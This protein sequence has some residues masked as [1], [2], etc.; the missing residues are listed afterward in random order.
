[1]VRKNEL[2]IF[3]N[4][5]CAVLALQS[6]AEVI[7]S[8]RASLADFLSLQA[9]IFK[10]H[11]K[12]FSVKYLYSIFCPPFQVSKQFYFNGFWLKYALLFYFLS[13]GSFLPKLLTLSRIKTSNFML[14]GIISI[15]G[16]DSDRTSVFSRLFNDE[17]FKDC[18]PWCQ[19]IIF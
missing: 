10:S 9:M 5:F 7:Q 17:I 11:P 3:V 19:Y 14:A 2:N 16:T 18:L 1:M 12:S 8:D 4:Q 15:S 6:N 13:V